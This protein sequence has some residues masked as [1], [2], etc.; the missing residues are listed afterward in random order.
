MY[1]VSGLHWNPS[2]VATIRERNCVL[3]RGVALFQGSIC[4][5]RVFLGLA[6]IEGCPHVR[7][8]LYE[9]T[10]QGGHAAVSETVFNTNEICVLMSEMPYIRNIYDRHSYYSDM[11]NYGSAYD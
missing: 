3:Y 6:F 10:S 4:T 5:K 7:G 8:G 1:G 11:N 2:I 9:H